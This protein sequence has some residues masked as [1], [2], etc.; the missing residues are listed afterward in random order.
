MLSGLAG[1]TDPK[2]SDWGER[3]LNTVASQTIR[4]LFTQSESVE[5]LVR[6]YPS[7]KLLQG[8][9]DS[10]KMSG[11]GLVI[12]RDFAIEEM[13]FETDAVSIDFS[14]VLSGKLKLKQPTQAVAQVVL[15]ESGINHAF[16]A[17]LVKKRLINLSEPAL[18][19]ISNGQ[20]VSFPEIKIQLLPEN[21]LHLIAKADINNGELVP[22]SMTISISIEKRRRVSFKDARFQLDEVPD[23][24]REI[25]QRLGAALVT[26]LD[27]MVDLDR[28]DLDGVKM[29]LNRLETQGEK[30]IFSGYAEIDHI[31]QSG[32]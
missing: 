10:F 22:L 14:S 3:M 21:R 12:R 9:I 7:S 13:C 16:K 4:H 29:R 32:Y 28:F 20:P 5:V 11:Q 17:E 18:M 26:I 23:Q 19:E 8:S 30:L 6:C 2:G 24:Q 1:L 27:G 25:S 31:P 15:L